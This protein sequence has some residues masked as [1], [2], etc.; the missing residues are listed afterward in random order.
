M[1]DIVFS[2]EKFMIVDLLYID[3]SYSIITV[4]MMPND[5]LQAAGVDTVGLSHNTDVL[6]LALV[7]GNDHV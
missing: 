6:I 3:F 5:W 1:L 4:W 7:L 2:L